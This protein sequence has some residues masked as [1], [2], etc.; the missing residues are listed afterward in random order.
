MSVAKN[1]GYDAASGVFHLGLDES[2][3]GHR[4][5]NFRFSSSLKYDTIE[6]QVFSCDREVAGW[7][8]SLSFT[9]G[10]LPEDTWV[11]CRIYDGEELIDSCSCRVVPDV[12]DL[13]S[14]VA[15]LEGMISNLRNRVAV[16]ADAYEQV[17]SDILTDVGFAELDAAIVGLVQYHQGLGSV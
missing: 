17:P 15:H 5:L 3:A 10:K 14:R 16:M 12:S 2:T 4:V 1:W 6:S 8:E 13:K 7:K 9:I 11:R